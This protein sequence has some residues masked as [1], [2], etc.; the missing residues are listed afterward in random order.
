MTQPPVTHRYLSHGEDLADV[1]RDAISVARA[2]NPLSRVTVVTP[3]YY[4]SFYLRRW[5]AAGGLLN[6]EFVR[7]EDIADLLASGLVDEIGGR[8]INRLEGAELVRQAVAQCIRSGTISG[9]IADIAW[10]PA[11]LSSLQ[12]TLRELEAQD[13][14]GRVTFRGIT[15]ADEIT[16]AIGNIWTAYRELK[17]SNSLFD[18]T[19]VASAAVTAIES[20]A[21]SSPAQTLAI[22]KI[23]VLAVAHPAPQYRQLWTA[24][25]QVPA[26]TTIFA[27]TG[28]ERSDNLMTEAVGMAGAAMAQDI[29][30]PVAEVVCA[31]DVRSEI[32]A[33]VSRIA[34]AAAAGIPFNR[35]AVLYGNP[36]YSVRIRSALEFADIP[37]AGPP[38]T[39]L[40][41]S[42]LGRFISGLLAVIESDLSRSETGDWLASCAIR[43]PGTK[44]LVNG[45]A[46]DRISKAARITSGAEIWR[47]QLARFARSKRRRAELIDQH[48][49]DGSNEAHSVRADALRAEAQAADDLL[50]FINSLEDD[51]KTPDETASWKTWSNWLAKLTERYMQIT[52]GSEA[53][54][55]NDRLTSL[56]QGISRLD[57][58]NSPPPDLEHFASVVAR[59]LSDTRSGANRLGRGV[60]VAPVRD[61]QGTRFDHVHVVGMV[62][63]TFPSPD[64]ADPLLSDSVRSELNVSC[65]IDLALSGVRLDEKRRQFLVALMAGSSVRHSTGLDQLEQV[66]RSPDL[67]S[68]LWN[69]SGADLA[70]MASMQSSSSIRRV[71]CHR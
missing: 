70:W 52:T 21:L 23:I 60:F 24:L 49:E 11:F 3:S 29:N 1:L 62:D 56:L 55:S 59:E 4:S 57:A 68:G 25:T 12:R 42:S 61:V 6:V 34:A 35:I 43:D 38:Q 28:D 63:G 51:V 33:V 18:R 5:L 27:T 36:A 32:A 39:S 7:I 48:G 16:T 13:V 40:I 10:Q 53:E 30:A 65:R 58:L 50:R 9:R 71:L 20:G 54:D 14:D 64:A 44:Q 22:G 69:R 67:H 66:L 31:E 19:Q 8:P 37:V 41:G 2:S 17:L 15:D 45:V 47:S 26:S 46:W